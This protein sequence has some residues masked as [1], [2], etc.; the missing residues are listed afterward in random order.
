METF[1]RTGLTG[2]VIFLIAVAAAAAPPTAKAAEPGGGGTSSDQ[3][4]I[5]VPVAAV[6]AIAA[7]AGLAIWQNI[8]DGKKKK[9][10]Q[11]EEEAELKETEEFDKYFREDLASEEETTVTP[12]GEVKEVKEPATVPSSP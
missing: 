8:N 7:F 12:T 9:Q 5:S 1:L 3:S 6:V 10:K 4:D 2:A 11:A